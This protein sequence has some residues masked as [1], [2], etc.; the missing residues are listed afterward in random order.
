M[1]SIAAKRDGHQLGINELCLGI[2]GH[3][4]VDSGGYSRFTWCT[5]NTLQSLVFSLNHLERA[6][7][8]ELAFSACVRLRTT[9]TLVA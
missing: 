2:T 7:R 5:R 4:T 3:H 9:K 1:R 6:T 8:I